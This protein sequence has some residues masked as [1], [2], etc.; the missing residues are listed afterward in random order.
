VSDLETFAP[1][2]TDPDPLETP[3]SSEAA[4]RAAKALAEAFP[5]LVDR[6]MDG[7]INGNGNSGE[8]HH[9]HEATSWD[10]HRRA[11]RPLT[12]YGHGLASWA[13]GIAAQD[14][15]RIHS[16]ISVGLTAGESNTDIAHRVIGSRH[17][18]GVNGATEVTRQHIL[19]LGKGLLHKR[20]S[21]LGGSDGNDPAAT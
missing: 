14:G 13:R 5:D 9:E 4:A 7:P 15:N 3:M 8:G 10:R 2:I 16:A 20:K 17:L 18:N 1:W 6:S 21:R 12:I 11:P 19:R